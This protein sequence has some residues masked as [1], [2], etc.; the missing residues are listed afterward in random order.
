MADLHQYHVQALWLGRA[1]VF[2]AY[3][4]ESEEGKAEALAGARCRSSEAE[5]WHMSG[6]TQ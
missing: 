5:E 3:L 6:V 4:F 1:V 2:P